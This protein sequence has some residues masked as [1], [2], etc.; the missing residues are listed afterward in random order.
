MPVMRTLVCEHGEG[1]KWERESQRGRRPRFCPEH[2]GELSPKM[3]TESGTSAA[4][5]LALLSLDALDTF[6]PEDQRKVE[7]VADQLLYR[8]REDADVRLLH[9]TLGQLSKRVGL[10]AVEA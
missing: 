2:R 7:Y 4:Q 1:H 10:C 8:E 9:D 5:A 3:P 6:R